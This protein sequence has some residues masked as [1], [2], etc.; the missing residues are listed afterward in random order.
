MMTGTELAVLS[1]EGAGKTSLDLVRTPPDAPWMTRIEAHPSWETLSQL[2][3]TMRVGVA[4]NRFRVR[5]LLTLKVGQVFES[6]S[7]ETE[8]V[9]LMVGQ[10]QLGWSEF[11]VVDQR[12]GLRV[13]RLG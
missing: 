9:P 13:T 5:D 2:R 10:V 12:M 11:E 7:P 1:A 6:V 8:D 3:I 4:L